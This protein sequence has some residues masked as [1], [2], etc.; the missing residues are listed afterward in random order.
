MKLNEKTKLNEEAQDLLSFMNMNDENFVPSKKFEDDLRKKFIN[1]SMGIDTDKKFGFSFRMFYLSIFFVIL[2]SPIVALFST[3]ISENRTLAQ[4]TSEVYKSNSISS[5]IN[6]NS[7]IDS[8]L[9]D[10]L[11]LANIPILNE[12]EREFIT[13]TNIK[14]EK[15]EK[16]QGC[17]LLNDLENV[18]TIIIFEYYNGRDYRFKVHTFDTQMNENGLLIFD[19]EKYF[20]N[21][22]LEF[23][24]NINNINQVNKLN[25]GENTPEKL[26]YDNNQLTWEEEVDCGGN[27]ILLNNSL[28][29]DYQRNIQSFTKSVKNNDGSKNEI[30]KMSFEEIELTKED[31]IKLDNLFDI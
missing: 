1:K 27:K 25:I 23:S 5:L 31:I 10:F 28:S 13:Q 12:G 11:N 30:L 16:Y 15:K 18:D 26:S 24:K 22:G 4:V 9:S 29:F 2:L 21:K 8:S 19:G 17:S 7:D 20:S 6:L 14:I 3:R